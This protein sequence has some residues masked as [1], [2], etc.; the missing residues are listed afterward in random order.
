MP[1]RLGALFD[2]TE[3]YNDPRFTVEEVYDIVRGI[4]KDD[5]W[6]IRF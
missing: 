2:I 5:G 1:S 3:V 4:L 6:E